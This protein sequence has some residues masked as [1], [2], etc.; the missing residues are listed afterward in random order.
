MSIFPLSLSFWI[1]TLVLVIAGLASYFS[2]KLTFAASVTGVLVAVLIYLG[3]GFPGL[4]MLA[5]FFV[6]GTAVTSYKKEEK[7][8]MGAVEAHE[9]RRKASQVLANAGVG[10]VLSLLCIFFEPHSQVLLVMIAGSFASATGDTFSSELGNV[11]GRNFYNILT[12]KKDT[13]GLNGVI[14]FE[15]T[16]FGIIGS[17]VIA[18]VHMIFVGWSYAFS[19]IVVAGIAGNAFDSLLGALFERKHRLG[20]DAVNVLNTAFGA[21]IALLLFEL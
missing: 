21:L 13:R 8:K 20:N 4:V 3:A 1:V 2:G 9:G 11:Y 14:S 19:I 15:G 17:L 5:V 18:L 10:A 12:L 6:L 7:L 16:V